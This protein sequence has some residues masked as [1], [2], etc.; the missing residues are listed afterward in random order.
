MKDGENQFSNGKPVS[1][2]Q[3][4]GDARAFVTSLRILATT[5]VHTEFLGHDYV[6]DK[7]VGHQGL[8]GLATLIQSE[9]Q[10]AASTGTPCLLVDNGDILQGTALGDEM[11]HMPVTPAHPLVASIE[12]LR[13]DAIGIGNHDLDYGLAY[14]HRLAGLSRVPFLSTNLMLDAPSPIQK[15]VIVDCDLNGDASDGIES[16][17]IGF[18]SVL[19]TLTSIWNKPMLDGHAQIAPAEQSLAKAIPDLQAQGA[20]VIILLAHMGLED[21][22]TPDDVRNLSNLLGV[23]AMIAGHTH[24]R[25]P[26]LDHQGFSDVDINKGALGPCPA[27]MPGFNASDLA[28]LDLKLRC[29]DSGKWQVLDHEVQLKANTSDIPAAPEITALLAPAHHSTRAKLAQPV[30]HCLYPLHNFFSLAMP[31]ETCALMASTKYRIV[32]EQLRGTADE[33]LP[34]LAAASAH[35]AGGRGG[36]NHFLNIAPGVIYRR[37]LAGLN[38]YSNAICALRL[39]GAELRAWLENT[40]QIYTTLCTNQPDQPLLRQDRPTFHFDTIYGLRYGID[41]TQPKGARITQ[42][43]FEGAPLDDEQMFVL[44]TNQFRAAGGGRDCRVENIQIAAQCQITVADALLETLK[45][46]EGACYAGAHPWYFSCENPV[47]AVLQT[48]AAALSHLD[49][50]AHLT[51]EP[52]AKDSDGFTQLRLNL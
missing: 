24:R 28:V 9:R 5:D 41:P 22:Q 34:L 12:A 48:S 14:L 32:K 16:P 45:S 8:A 20:D 44:A 35:T 4:S 31:T 3:P 23:D 17:R 40:V 47:Q 46:D 51:P 33:G 27:A 30:G 2:G 49:D 50:I 43:E 6:L 1:L 15:S 37:A 25:L 21:T 11:A 38:P 19:P 13:Y 10:D 36:P 52:M 39:S 18:L 7:S 29:D 42:I 26:G